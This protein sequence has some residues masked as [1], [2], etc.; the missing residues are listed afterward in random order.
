MYFNT[1]YS[2]IRLAVLN[3]GGEN[4]SDQYK[5]QPRIH[6]IKNMSREVRYWGRGNVKSCEET[7]HA[8]VNGILGYFEKNII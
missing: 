2:L 3:F 6:F 4:D 8:Y 5:H 1:I 7:L